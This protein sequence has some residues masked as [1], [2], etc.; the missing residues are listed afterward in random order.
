[1]LG[2]LVTINLSRVESVRLYVIK[3]TITRYHA[4]LDIVLLD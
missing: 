3:Q 4:S 1:M 2:E